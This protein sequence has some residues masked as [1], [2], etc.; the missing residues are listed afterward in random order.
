MSATTAVDLKASAQTAVR[1]VS[2][3]KKIKE[4]E[5]GTGVARNT[6]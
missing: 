2:K 3:R 1:R 6:L 4:I 5:Q